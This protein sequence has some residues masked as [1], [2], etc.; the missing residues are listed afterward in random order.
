MNLPLPEAFIDARYKNEVVV[1]GD[2]DDSLSFINP[3]ESF[4]YDSF[5]SLSRLIS[6]SYSGCIS[7]SDSPYHF[8][9]IYNSKNEVIELV[10]NIN[11]FKRYII[12]YN[13]SGN[14]TKIKCF[15]KYYDKV[16]IDFKYKIKY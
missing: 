4:K 3:Q 14:I 1:I 2:K 16:I 8:H 6:F 7:C 9:V 12:K 11:S 10:N 15:T 5:D 13:K